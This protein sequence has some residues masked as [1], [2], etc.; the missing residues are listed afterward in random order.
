MLGKDALESEGFARLGWVGII[1][2]IDVTTGE[3]GVSRSPVDSDTVHAVGFVQST[4]V[5]KPFWE[6]VG[7][8]SV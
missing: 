2:Y 4:I 6:V 7:V 3:L 1:G 5:T 8:E